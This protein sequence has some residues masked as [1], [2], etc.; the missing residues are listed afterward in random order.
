M[1]NQLEAKIEEWR[2]IAEQIIKKDGFGQPCNDWVLTGE[3]REPLTNEYFVSQYYVE[4]GDVDAG[5]KVREDQ[6]IRFGNPIRQ[7]LNGH[8]LDDTLE[9]GTKRFIVR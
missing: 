4:I 7:H 2:K 5:F 1:P 8:R 6:S 9:A 3:F